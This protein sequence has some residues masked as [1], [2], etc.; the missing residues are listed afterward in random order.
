[1][2][3]KL[4]NTLSRKKE[5]FKPVKKGKV[6]M[7]VCGPTVYNYV[8][9]GNL[10][11]Y[12]FGDI[13]RRHLKSLGLK[14]NHVMNIT[15]VDDKTI[16]DS[17][18]QGKSL[19]ELANFYEKAFLEDLK[20]MNIEKPEVIPHATDHVKEMVAL[21]KNLLAKGIAYK[22]EDGIYFSIDKFK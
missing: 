5:V 19:K 6:G 13:L 20:D 4:Y 2:A 9:I 10:R 11:A 8:H 15:D 17:Q 22:T 16:R 12:I 3:L 21:I 18:K 7:Y 14:V 1:M